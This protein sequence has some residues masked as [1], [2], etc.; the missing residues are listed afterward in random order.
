MRRMAYHLLAVLI[1]AMTASTIKA[2]ILLVT[3]GTPV[4]EY[5]AA[6]L[7]RY[8]YQLSGRLLSV[9]HGEVPDRKTEFVLTRLDHPLMTS[10]KDNGV[11]ALASVPGAQGYVIRTVKQA[12]G[13]YCRCGCQWTALWRIWVIGGS[14]RNAFLYERGCVSR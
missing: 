6:E 11:L 12:T 10:W 13:G 5:A 14:F 2:Q 1:L 4:E 7:Q 8:Y 9:G 3:S